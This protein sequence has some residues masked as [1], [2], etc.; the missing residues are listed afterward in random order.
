M[1]TK[2]LWDISSELQEIKLEFCYKQRKSELQDI[3]SSEKKAFDPRYKLG[4][5]KKQTKPELCVINTQL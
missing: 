1:L 5:A 3:N 4:I 2:K